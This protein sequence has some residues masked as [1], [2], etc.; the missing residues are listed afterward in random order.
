M[1]YRLMKTNIH[2]LCIRTQLCIILPI[3]SGRM[4]TDIIIITVP[5]LTMAGQ[6]LLHPKQGGREEEQAI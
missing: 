4:T 2:G 5:G 3:L 6:V 1:F